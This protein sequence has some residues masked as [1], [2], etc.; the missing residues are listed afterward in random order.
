M[1]SEE[2]FNINDIAEKF[3]VSVANIQSIRKGITWKHIKLKNNK[4]EEQLEIKLDCKK[5]TKKTDKKIKKED[6]FIQ[7]F[8]KKLLNIKQG[9]K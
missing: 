1:L 2:K 9:G 4:K 5:H 7:K 8:A 3:N 6:N